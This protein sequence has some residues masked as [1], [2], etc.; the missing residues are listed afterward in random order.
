MQTQTGGMASCAALPGKLYSSMKKNDS[1]GFMKNSVRM[2]GLCVLA[3]TGLAWGDVSVAQTQKETTPSSAAKPSATIETR[4]ASAQPAKPELT[5]TDIE[6]FLDGIMPAQLE[7]ENVAGAVISVVKDG[8]LLFAKGY[9]YADMEK[10]QPVTADTTLFRPGSISKLF[11]W[12]SVMQLVEQGKLDLDKDV[13]GYIDFEIPPAYGKPVTLRDIMTHTGGFEETVRDLFVADAQHLTPLDQYLK[14]RLPPRIFPPFVVPAY[15]NYATTLAGY[16]VQRVSGRPFEQYVA[17]NIFAP[18]D[19]KRTTFVQ[20]LPAELEP[21]MSKGYRKASDKPKPFEFVEVFPAGSVSTTARDMANFMITHLQDGKFG[22]KQI[23]RPETAKLMH[24]RTFGSD[25]RLNGMALGFYEESRNGQRIIGHGGDTELFHSDLH[26]L[27]DKNV[28]FFV[29]YNSAGRGE[30][31]GRGILFDKFIDR[32]FPYDPVPAAKIE[33]AKADAASIAGLYQV[34]RRADSSFLKLFSLLGQMKVIANADGTISIDPLKAPNDE[35]RKFEEVQ[36]FLFREVNGQDKVA[37]KKD[38]N[39]NW[40][41]QVEIPVFIFQKVDFLENK[42]FNYALL[43]FG[44]SIV[45]LTVLLW[46]VGALVRKHYAHPLELTPAERRQRLLVRLICLLFLGLLVGWVS[47]ISAAED[48]ATLNALP[49]RIILFGFLGLLC[50]FGTIFVLWNAL[51]SWRAS[52][53]WIWAKLHDV[54]LALACV[55]LV[56]FLVY[57]KLMNFNVHF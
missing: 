9:G 50:L 10:R 11:T 29:S 14:Q 52:N 51:K 12:T 13:N 35:L 6:A 16:I 33:N 55:S 5:S 15:S 48:I 22:D 32:Y 2:I 40:Q 39:G 24:S 44:L 4:P 25:D 54:A 1:G 56:W 43:I 57:W 41:F 7:R 28:G 17:E 30:V 37:F 46:P 45:A 36:P 21:L 26:L 49:G 23:L 8:K 18:L 31:S 53:R 34:S 3:V 27:L 47:A 20:P 19:M 42:Y 38:A